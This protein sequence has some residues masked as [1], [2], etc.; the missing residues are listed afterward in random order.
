MNPRVRAKICGLTNEEDARAAIALGADALGFNLWPGSKR[1]LDLERAASWISRL[2]PFVT[3]VAVLVNFPL[4]EARR[5][6]AHPAIDAVQ[7]HGDEDEKYC[8]EF[9]KAGTPFLKAIRVRDADSLRDLDRFATAGIL[10]DADAGAA[11]GG[12]GR[13]LDPSLAAEAQRRFPALQVVLA[14][15]LN[16]ENVAE[17]V[18]IAQPYGVDVASGVESAP[19]RKEHEKM[20]RFLAAL[21]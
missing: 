15:G 14:G 19:G 8:A 21:R 18:R 9:A 11:Y 6:A 4:E 12:T 7:F 2:P 16:P 20:R 1:Y 13:Q 5:V 17:A 10:V 3:R